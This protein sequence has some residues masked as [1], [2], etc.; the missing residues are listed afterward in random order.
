[1]IG[2]AGF[3]VFAWLVGLGSFGGGVGFLFCQLKRNQFSIN[4][5]LLVDMSASVSSSCFKT[6]QPD[7]M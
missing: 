2:G 6:N 1:M 3:W 7:K 5:M 4:T